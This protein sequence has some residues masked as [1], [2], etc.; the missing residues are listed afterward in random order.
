M[1]IAGPLARRAALRVLLVSAGSVAASLLAAC[2]ENASGSTATNSGVGSPTN[3]PVTLPTMTTAGAGSPTVMPAMAMASVPVLSGTTG[4]T[5]GTS[6][7]PAPVT[8]MGGGKT[9]PELR[10]GVEAL[11]DSMDPQQA[12]FNHWFRVHYFTFDTLIRRDFLNGNQLVP[13]LATDWKRT[14]GR[15]LEMNLR[16][17]VRWQ[18]GTMFTAADV[19]YTFNRLIGPS[20]NTKL[21][22]ASPTY[23][24]LDRVEQLDEYRVRFVSTAIDPV[25]EK[26]FA[27]LGAQIIPAA[28]HKQV[29]A[30]AFQTKPIGT[31]PYRLVEFAKGDHL[32]FEAN[33][34][35]FGGVPAAKKV[36]LR[37]IPELAT[38]L[39]AI[40]NGEVDLITTLPPDQIGPLTKNPALVIRSVPSS[41]MH[42]FRYTIKVKPFDKREIRQAV[43]YAID[44][45]TLTEQLWNG[46]AVQTRGFQYEGEDFYDASRPFTPYN[47]ER[48]KQLLQQGGYAGEDVVILVTSPATYTYERE[49]SEVV[50]EMWRR[51][52]INA[53]LDFAEFTQKW[54]GA[55]GDTKY[56][57]ASS[58]INNSL[59]DPDGYLWRGWGADNMEQVKGWWPATDAMEFNRLGRDARTVLDRSQRAADYKQMIDIF[60]MESPG[61]TLYLPKES[62]A[63]RANID[64]TPY[65]IYYMD[66][67][68]YNFKVR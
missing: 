63:M 4:A 37:A 62:Y 56:H 43:N 10:V 18:D 5:T 46:Y 6:T 51:V 28:Y 49:S 24:P 14:D 57:A 30:D 1:Q 34:E 48:A 9:I 40:Q 13:S 16:R 65:S 15:T 12:I 60:E 23:F 59:A 29:G 19:A 35:Y 66:L 61:T 44:R 32:T 25:I 20:R 11:P 39:A 42:V 26:R 33:T 27:G 45:Q 7:A 52:G 67:R 21:E 2:G 54:G 58:T 22:V 53:K 36:T 47:P 31:G 41:A 64:W 8:M 55:F 3:A 50:A 38:R 68:P 17:D